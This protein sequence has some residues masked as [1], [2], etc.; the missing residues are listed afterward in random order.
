MPIDKE[1]VR[2]LV[3]DIGYEQA[4]LRTGI[5]QGTLRQWAARGQW[6]A[7]RSHAQQLVTTVTQPK[8]AEAHAEALADLE[9]ETRM[10]LAKASRRMAKDCEELPV[11]HAGLANT[12]AKTMAIVHRQGDQAQQ[13][14]SLN[15]L[16]LGQLQIGIQQS[17]TQDTDA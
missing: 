11:R 4:S 1:Q 16:N 9:G 10:S 8:I 7:T 3:A 15:V 14:F 12:V 13:G 2:M 17:S 6:N 5:K